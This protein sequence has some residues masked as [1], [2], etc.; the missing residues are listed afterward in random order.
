[1]KKL[2]STIA[3]EVKRLRGLT[4]EQS[5]FGLA[6]L[7]AQ[8]ATNTAQA[9]A[10]DLG[11]LGKLTDLSKSIEDMAKSTAMGEMDNVRM[12]AWLADSLETTL[13]KLGL[14]LEDFDNPEK[15]E[16]SG[17]GLSNSNSQQS[18][19]NISAVI[20]TVT[21]NSNADLLIEI[22]GLRAE[23]AEL[24]A[25][26]NA[27]AQNTRDLPQM[28]DQFDNVTEGGNGMR[29]KVMNDIVKVKVLA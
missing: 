8:F 14:K 9:R 22:R 2:G 10:G 24:K 26:A 18:S 7:Q 28:A 15:T 23:V 29:A 12:R 21:V 13:N 17:S 16:V 6:Y 3:D 1:M 5:E 11:A 19:D 20:R 25:A 27:T 4:T